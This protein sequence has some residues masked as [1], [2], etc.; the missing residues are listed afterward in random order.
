M[1]QPIPTPAPADLIAEYV[2]LRDAKKAEEE[3]FK[4]FLN[5]NY[6]VRMDAIEQL[7]LAK[8]NEMKTDSLSAR[9]TG[10]AYKKRSVSVTVADMREFQRHVIG[11]EHWE[12]VDWRANKSQVTALVDAEE[13]L[14]PGVNF[15][16]TQTVGIRKS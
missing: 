4:D 6:G 16:A 14:P 5:A 1:T 15:T 3:K 11:G 8:L 7:L 9:G 2:W 12:L 10:T 13:P